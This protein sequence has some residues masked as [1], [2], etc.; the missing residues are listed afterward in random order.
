MH[1][2]FQVK[3]LDHDSGIGG[4]WSLRI[5]AQNK[6]VD[7]TRSKEI[8]F[9]FYIVDEAGPGFSPKDS[10]G[11]ELLVE[12]FGSNSKRVLTGNHSYIG[13]WQLGLHSTQMR[14][15]DVR[16][17]GS[18]LTSYHNITEEVQS[19]IFEHL[20]Q[21]YHSQGVR[22]L[23]ELVVALPDP[24]LWME[25]AMEHPNFA[26]IQITGTLPFEVE[27]VFLTGEA[28]TNRFSSLMGES[29]TKKLKSKTQE[30]DVEFDQKFGDQEITEEVQE[31][32]K[33]ILSNVLGGIGYFYGSSKVKLPVEGQTEGVGFAI[34]DHF[35]TALLTATPS[36]SFFPRGFLWDEGFHQVHS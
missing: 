28:Q 15:L 19:L 1:L 23:S 25:S 30:F 22:N 35:E 34:K 6:E 20:S 27:F 26:V 3:S 4:D 24:P 12:E 7:Q 5:S 9:L 10:L 11:W 18:P 2:G 29:F 16:K 36:R 17:F 31:A 13:Q 21:Q 8:S 14:N 32:K 33:K